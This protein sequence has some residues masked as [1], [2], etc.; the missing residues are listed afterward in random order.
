[1]KRQA[2]K[3]TEWMYPK[4]RNEKK[5]ISKE[6][7]AGMQDRGS[8]VLVSLSFASGFA[9]GF[10]IPV[11]PNQAVGSVSNLLQNGIN[12]TSDTTCPPAGLH[13]VPAVPA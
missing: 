6:E 8:D 9:S 12:P 11:A 1:M 3:A 10:T 2:L 13:T 5:I 7:L 4:R